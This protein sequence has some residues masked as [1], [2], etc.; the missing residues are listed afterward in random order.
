MKLKINPIFIVLLL[1]PFMLW[2]VILIL[3]TYDDWSS[4]SSP[5]FD[6][7]FM[8]YFLP[9]GSV[10]RPF[11]AA[12]G[13]IT[14]FNYH[15]FPAL[16]HICVVVGHILSTFVV[17]KLCGKLRFNLS[18][19]FIATIFFFLS[20]CMLGTVLSVDGLNQT[21]AHLWGLLSVYAYLELK[22]RTKY[23][24]WI[25]CIIFSVLSKDNGIAWSIVP[26]IMAWGF[27]QCDFRTLKRDVLIGFGI[28]VAYLIIRVMLPSTTIYNPEYHTFLLTKKLREI[29]MFVAYTWIAADYVS[30]IHQPSR[31]IILGAITV[32]MSLPFVYYLFIVKRGLWRYRKMWILTLSI[33]IA[34]SPHLLITMSVMNAYAPLGLV[35]L[36]VAYICDSFGDNNKRLEI[37]F[38]FFISAAL[39]SDVHHWL[40]AWR[41]SLTGKEM[42][43]QTIKSTGRPV[44]SAYCIVVKDNYP[45]FSSFCVVPSDAFGNGQ[46]VVHETGYAWPKVIKDTTIEQNNAKQISTIANNAFNKGFECVWLVNGKSIKVIR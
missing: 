27:K 36:M 34:A 42:A 5:N 35:A 26:P 7:H 43:I 10:W 44:K 46:A 23:I 38:L 18:A 14:A 29:G 41:T 28:A 31:N 30:I 24:V 9:Y 11:D 45:K 3:P 12:I 33:L 32:L 17:Y 15:L 22:G 6:H 37:A 40:K 4:L 19:T 25:I 20:P 8:K 1:S 16:N 39:I 13:Y 21:Y 2:A